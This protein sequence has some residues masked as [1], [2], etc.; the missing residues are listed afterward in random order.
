MRLAIVDDDRATRFL[1]EQM[2]QRLGHATTC[3]EAP[4]AA[5]QAVQAAPGAFD[6]L[7]TDHGMPGTSGIDLARAVREASPGLRVILVSGYV[8]DELRAGAAAAGVLQV[9][10]KRLSVK[11]LCEQIHALIAAPG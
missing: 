8:T 6:A 11:E 10:P 7:V 9:L 1:M 2:L 4:A 3:F 5:L